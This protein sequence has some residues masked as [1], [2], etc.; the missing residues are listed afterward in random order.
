VEWG[1]GGLGEGCGN[2]RKLGFTQKAIFT[3]DEH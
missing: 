1:E 2:K 3:T